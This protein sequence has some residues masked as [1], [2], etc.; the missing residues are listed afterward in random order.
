MVPLGWFWNVADFLVMLDG[1]WNVADFLM[2]INNCRYVADFLMMI[3]DCWWWASLRR[4]SNSRRRNLGRWFLG[5]SSSRRRRSS[6]GSWL[7]RRYT[8]WCRW[9]FRSRRLESYYLLLPLKITKDFLDTARLSKDRNEGSGLSFPISFPFISAFILMILSWLT[10]EK[11]LYNWKPTA[12][13]SHL[14]CI[15]LFPFLVKR[16]VSTVKALL[17]S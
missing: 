10:S 11:P 7:R 9:L 5:R 1:R 4:R 13:L 15:N 16:I 2:M 6:R 3:E 17:L 12:F 8:G 14:P